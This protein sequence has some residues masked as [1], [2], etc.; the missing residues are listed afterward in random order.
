[1]PLSPLLAEGLLAPIFFAAGCALLTV[2][3]LRRS[4]R[5]FGNRRSRGDSSPPIELQHRPTHKWDGVKKDA[6]ARFNRDQVELYDLA[7]DLKGQLDSKI[8]V[9]NELVAQ[10]QQQ[11]DRLEELLA[12]SK[13]S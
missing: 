7:R 1:M 13:K 3:L 2:I 9:V 10:S 8:I 12:E 6:A 4:Y 5:F 11:I